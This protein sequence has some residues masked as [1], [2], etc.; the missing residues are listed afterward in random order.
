MGTILEIKVGSRTYPAF[1]ENQHQWYTPDNGG[2]FVCNYCTSATFDPNGADVCKAGQDGHNCAFCE[3]KDESGRP[4]TNCDEDCEKCPI[5]VAPHNPDTCGPDTAKAA[6]VA[7]SPVLVAYPCKCGND[8]HGWTSV[9]T[10]AT[11]I[12]QDKDGHWPPNVRV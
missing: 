9:V 8:Y 3:E 2:H 6:L 11:G 10:E 1:V 7:K 4:C 12:T 5:R